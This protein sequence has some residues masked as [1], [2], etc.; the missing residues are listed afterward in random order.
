MAK[1]KRK[2]VLYFFLVIVIIGMIYIFFNEH[3]VIKYIRLESRVD[4][5]QVE[6]E[7]LKLQNEQFKNEIDSLQKQIPAKME[8]VARE[9]YNMKRESEIK[10]EVEEE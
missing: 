9:K 10:I 3:G 4:S 6:L 8:Q 2:Y 5:M 7:R 1:P